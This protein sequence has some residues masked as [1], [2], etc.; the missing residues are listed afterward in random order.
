M[1]VFT[2]RVTTV[3]ES[4]VGDQ[5]SLNGRVQSYRP[6]TAKLVGADRANEQTFVLSAGLSAAAISIAPLG[7]SA[8]GMLVYFVADR[9]CDIRVNSPSDAAF[10]S[11][12]QLLVLAGHL[13]NVFCSTGGY[14]TPVLLKVAGGSAATLST[15]F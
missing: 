3:W 12:V 11:G 4:M 14:D 2:S 7:V 15:S 6:D 10:L 8:P 13:S 1:P 5:F 9:P